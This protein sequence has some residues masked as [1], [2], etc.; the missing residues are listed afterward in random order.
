MLDLSHIINLPLAWGGIIAIA[1]FMYVFLDGFDLGVGILFPFAPSDACRKRMINSIAPFWDSNETW[2][3]LG[4]GGIFAAFPLAYSILM[5]A[6]YLPIMLM[7]ACLIFR[8]VAFEFQFKAKSHKAIKMWE[9]TFHFSSIL[10][11]FFQGLMLGT[12][13]QGISVTNNAFSGGPFDWISA[14]SFMSGLAVVFGYA[15][16]GANWI[17]YKTEGATQEWAR[18]CSTYVS[19]YVL[20]FMGLVSLWMPYIN[21]GVSHRWFSFP[22]ILFLS[23]IPIAVAVIF[24]MHERALKQKKEL[25][26]FLLSIAL[27]ALN[28]FGLAISIWPWLVPYKVDLWQAAAAPESQSI[29][30]IGTA[31]L[32]PIIL[33]YTAYAYYVFRG[34]VSEKNMYHH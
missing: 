18:K 12:I 26:P 7:L 23:P 22:N 13:V 14:F 9:Y 32:L 10:A 17:I 34:K 19:I 24:F 25:A 16:M 29:L 21:E 28:F 27:F 2:L 20:A 6:L 33:S 15:L 1:V 31:I 4:G 30:L 5:P 8:G 11:A 3:V